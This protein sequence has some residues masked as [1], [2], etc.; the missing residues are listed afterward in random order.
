MELFEH[1]EN[2]ENKETEQ[3]REIEEEYEK[4]DD[5]LESHI[6]SKC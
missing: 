3:D 5:D 4:L 2:G 1:D 6:R